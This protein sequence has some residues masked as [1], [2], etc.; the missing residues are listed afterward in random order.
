[1][2]EAKQGTEFIKHE[3]DEAI[4]IQQSICECGRTLAEEHPL[5]DA[6]AELRQMLK[7]DEEHL[8]KLQTLGK[9]FGA[10]GE[11]EEV[12]LAFEELGTEVSQT[13]K[14]GPES[15]KYELHAVVLNMKRKQQDSAQA[16]TKIARKMKDQKL[17]DEFSTMQKEI[18]QSADAMAKSLSELALQIATQ[19]MPTNGRS[20]SRSGSSRSRSGSASASR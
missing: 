9:P 7:K 17:V 5:E 10:T 20:G 1:M 18:K 3:F 2:S 14:G 8:R 13:A 11:K 4:A 12:A 15:E 16:M 19:G 6:R